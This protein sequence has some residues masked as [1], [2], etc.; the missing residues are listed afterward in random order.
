MTVLVV[1]V[2]VQPLGFRNILLMSFLHVE[3]IQGEAHRCRVF[4]GDTGTMSVFLPLKPAEQQ[5]Q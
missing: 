2:A 3:Y 5:G 1:L 4:Y